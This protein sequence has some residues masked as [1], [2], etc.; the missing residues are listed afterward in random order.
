MLHTKIKK[1]KRVMRKK[2]E[3]FKETG[4][5]PTKK[6]EKPKPKETVSWSKNKEAKEKK[7]TKK[8][9]REENFKRKCTE[10]ELE[11]LE[12]DL[13]LMKQHKKKKITNDEFE[14]QFM[15]EDDQLE[16]VP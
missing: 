13:R 15:T 14:K 1:N 7:Q 16:A 8:L 6:G 2:V 10:E 3:I 11:E 9:K 12:Q 4:T 5:W